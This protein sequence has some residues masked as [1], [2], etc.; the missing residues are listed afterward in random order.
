MGLFVVAF[1]IVCRNWHVIGAASF[2]ISADLSRTPMRYRCCFLCW[3]L[4]LPAAC[5]WCRFTRFLTTTVPKDQTA[6]TVAANN[7]VN[8]GAMVVGSL[9]ALGLSAAG[10]T[11]VNQL[12]LGAAMCLISAWLA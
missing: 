12:L 7:I 8:S 1:H 4:P 3:A 2:I 10:V 9:I 11:M 5:S 6:R